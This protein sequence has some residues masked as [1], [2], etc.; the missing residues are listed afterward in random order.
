MPSANNLPARVTVPLFQERKSTG[1]PLVV[2]TA[3]DAPQGRLADAAGVDAIL[4]GDSLA[5]VALGY[6]STL[7]VTLDDMLH[8]TRA[9]ARGQAARKRNTEPTEAEIA[10][11]ARQALLI[12]DLPFGSYGATVEDGVRAGMRLVAEGGAQAVKLEGAGQVMRETIQRLVDAGVPV[13]GHLGMT[14]QAMHRFGGF[15][16]QAKT[17]AAAAALISDARALVEAG[18]FSMVLEV[19]PDAVARRVTEAVSVPT[20]GIGAGGGCDGQVQVL[21]D[22]VGLAP[23]PV[24]KHARRYTEAGNAIREAISAYAADVRERRFPTDDNAF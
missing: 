11:G 10:R 2:V 8:H 6:D 21:H 23:G 20:I 24:R 17:E 12:A 22:L 18:V 3:Y 19:I 7:P 14:P 15:K 1:V 4:V 16:V 13:M 5:M 9:V